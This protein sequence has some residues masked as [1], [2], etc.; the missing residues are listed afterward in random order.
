MNGD[1]HR[2]CGILGLL[3]LLVHFHIEASFV[4]PYALLF[5][6]SVWFEPGS[7]LPSSEP[8]VERRRFDQPV[9]ASVIRMSILRRGPE[10][11]LRPQ[12]TNDVDQGVFFRVSRSQRAV[13][14]IEKLD[15]LG[16][17]NLRCPAGLFH[18]F[19]G[20]TPGTR[21]TSGQMHDGDASPAGGEERQRTATGELD[22]VGVRSDCQN[23]DC[24]E[25]APGVIT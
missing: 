3:L 20:R 10:N 11:H 8:S 21:L 2:F 6:D 22:V 17:Q 24:H 12:A 4:H 23:I 7:S 1:I 9:A 14:T 18:P 13:A 5:G 25:L 16:A 19:C 15:C